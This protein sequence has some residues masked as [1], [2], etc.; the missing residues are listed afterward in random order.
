PAAIAW[1]IDA[2]D[3]KPDWDR[4][5]AGYASSV[6]WPSCAFYAELAERYPEAKVILTE[7]DA[8]SWFRSIQDTIFRNAV[9]PDTDKPFDRMFRKVIGEP[10]GFRMREHDNVVEVYKRHNAEV[11]RRIAPDRL[12]VYTVEQGWEPLCRFL[13][14]PAPDAPMP[15]LNS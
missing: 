8:E 11:K 7:R 1:W 2:A 15:Q 9:P 4:I 3:G 10:F 5:F 12:L 14:V 13:G 6:D